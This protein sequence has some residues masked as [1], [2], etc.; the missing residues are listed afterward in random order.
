MKYSSTLSAAQTPTS[1]VLA[2]LLAN[3]VHSLAHAEMRL[4]LAR[5]LWNFDLELQIDSQ[6]WTDQ[7]IFNF[8][9]KG[10]LNVKLR[11]R[12]QVRD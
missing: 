11:P 9:Q 8:W 6:H 1:I 10:P 7:Q 2:S 3:S 12:F 5:V 4:I